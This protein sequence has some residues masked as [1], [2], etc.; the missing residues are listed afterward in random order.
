M[1]EF[2]KNWG[3]K[4]AA[5]NPAPRDRAVQKTAAMAPQAPSPTVA[6]GAAK[7]TPA[8]PS[9]PVGEEPGFRIG[10]TVRVPGLGDFTVH[11]TK[12]GKGKSGM[13]LVYI[14]LDVASMTPYAVKTT[15]RWNPSPDTRGMN[16][17]ARR[18]SGTSPNRTVPRRRSGSFSGMGR[19]RTTN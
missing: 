5:G 10:Q 19:S 2:L 1:F 9:E 3:K 12:G 18:S 17:S 8:K 11:D 16:S 6:A 15:S 14:V 4:K 13:G 7:P